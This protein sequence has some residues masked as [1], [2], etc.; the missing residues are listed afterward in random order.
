MLLWQTSKV[1][2]VNAYQFGRGFVPLNLSSVLYP[3]PPLRRSHDLF[4]TCGGIGSAKWLNSREQQPIGGPHKIPVKRPKD[5]TGL[6]QRGSGLPSSTSG[7]DIGA[8][9]AAAPAPAPAA[10]VAAKAEDLAE[11]HRVLAQ[12][13]TEC[14]GRLQALRAAAEFS[15]ED[16][17]KV[18]A[19]ALG[20]EHCTA[21][22]VCELDAAAYSKAVDMLEV[23]ANLCGDTYFAERAVDRK[24]EKMRSCLN[25]FTERQLKAR[26]RQGEAKGT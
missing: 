8:A 1:V 6:I 10:P 18:Q 5:E 22:V 13:Q 16:P 24:L 2:L 23:N 26:H 9:P 4:I 12:I 15:E 11:L 14:A 19:A 20:L 7:A 3:L 21:R 17:L 25:D